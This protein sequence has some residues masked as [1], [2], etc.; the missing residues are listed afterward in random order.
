MSFIEFNGDRTD[1]HFLFLEA[2]L[3]F[4]GVT[5]NRSFQKIDGQDGEVG[6]GDGTLNNIS[7]SYPFR[8]RLP[9]GIK[10]EDEVTVISNWLSE[11]ADW[12]DFIFGG[13]PN[14]VYRAMYVGEYDIQ[15]IVSCYGKCV[16]NFKLKPYKFLKSGLVEQTLSTSITNPTK[17]MAR[18]KIIIK[19]AG[20]IVLRIGSSTYSLKDV[21]GGIIIDVLYDQVKSLDGQRPQWNKITTYPLPGINPGLNNVLTTGSV[22]EMKIV[23]RWEVIV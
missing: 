11:D 4:D 15:R 12:H 8:L 6:T 17:R 18:P 3:T 21:D 22:T 9:K 2:G 10:I 14:Y 16:L 20:N 1:N 7:R 19:G 23:P 13:D 5:R